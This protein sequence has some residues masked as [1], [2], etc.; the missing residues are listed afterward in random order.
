MERTPTLSTGTTEHPAITRLRPRYTTGVTP[1]TT[2]LIV[3]DTPQGRGVDTP[4]CP[5]PAKGMRTVK[6][7]VTSLAMFPLQAHKDLDLATYLLLLT[8]TLTMPT[9]LTE[10]R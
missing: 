9:Q 10:L 2:I 7:A 1:T 4:P 6:P 5:P 3:R 8:L